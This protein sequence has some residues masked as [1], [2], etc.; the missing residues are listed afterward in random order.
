[1]PGDVWRASGPSPLCAG[2]GL[3][4]VAERH[5]PTAPQ[6]HT[7]PGRAALIACKPCV[8][9][10]SVWCIDSGTAAATWSTSA[11]CVIH[12]LLEAGTMPQHLPRGEKSRREK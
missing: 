2:C 5:A 9:T 7:L 1:M 6:C 12:A 8:L 3:H 10:V 11:A 4:A